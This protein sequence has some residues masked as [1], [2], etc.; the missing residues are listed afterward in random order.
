LGALTDPTARP[1]EPLSH[2]MPFGSGPGPDPVRTDPD[3]E[4]IFRLRALYSQTESP[5]LGRLLEA[6]EDN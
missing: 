5:A 2:G 6:W 3:Q 4:A 1:D